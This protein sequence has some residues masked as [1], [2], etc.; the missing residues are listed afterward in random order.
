MGSFTVEYEEGRARSLFKNF[1]LG[2]L[3]PLQRPYPSPAEGFISLEYFFDFGH[4][5]SG[6]GSQWEGWSCCGLSL[7]R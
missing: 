2:Q 6:M 4:V 1:L 3:H 5:G 7:L